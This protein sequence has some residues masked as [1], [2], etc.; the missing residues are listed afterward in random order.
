M[1]Y[2]KTSGHYL[3]EEALVIYSEHQA[4]RSAFWKVAIHG[5]LSHSLSFMSEYNFELRRLSG[6]TIEL[7]HYLSRSISP[8]SKH[9]D[10]E[11]P[12]IEQF[13]EKSQKRESV[14]IIQETENN[15]SAEQYKHIEQGER[16]PGIIG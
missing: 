12:N 8:G 1:F 3:I 13:A 9:T 2:L 4:L 14:A 15:D 10:P 7:T 11:D 16:I 5:R 6:S